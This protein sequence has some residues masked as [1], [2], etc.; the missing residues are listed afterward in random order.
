MH[1]VAWDEVCKPKRLGGLGVN[2]IRDVNKALLATW[3]WYFSKEESLWCKVVVEKY[4]LANEWETK[5]S[6]LPYGCGCWKAIMNLQADFIKETKV[7]VGSGTSTRFW[8]DR[9][10]SGR[11]LMMEYP[12]I[13]SLARNKEIRVADC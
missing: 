12:I 8:M 2:K 10:C 5:K 6:S 3:L 7:N 9:W 11:P 1:L 4:G 13:Y